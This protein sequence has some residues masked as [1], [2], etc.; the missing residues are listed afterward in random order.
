[1]FLSQ[2]EPEHR[3]AFA[4]ALERAAGLAMGAGVQTRSRRKT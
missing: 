4:D 2:I 3:Q 1:M